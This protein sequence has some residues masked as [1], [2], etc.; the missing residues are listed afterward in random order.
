MTIS[1]FI[2]FFLLRN[3]E[4]M[5]VTATRAITTTI[6]GETRKSNSAL[7]IFKERSFKLN[8]N[9]SNIA[10][11][12]NSFPVTRLII[13]SRSPLCLLSEANRC[14]KTR[15]IPPVVLARRIVE[16]EIQNEKIN[17]SHGKTTMKALRSLL[18]S[19]ARAARA[20]KRR[21]TSKS[22]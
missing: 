2:S 4:N 16:A 8:L 18:R 11:G 12:L 17:E 3:Q 15:A 9:L 14:A 5:T 20:L 1:S 10:K 6:E 13:M 22:T 21:R 19:V 7:V